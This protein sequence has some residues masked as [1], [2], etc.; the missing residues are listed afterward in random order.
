MLITII[1]LALLIGVGIIGYRTRQQSPLTYKKLLFV[2]LIAY[3]VVRMFAPVYDVGAMLMGLFA[4]TIGVLL[5]E[6]LPGKSKNK[7][8]SR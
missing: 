6:V 4:C 8:P 2:E 1:E 7:R 5:A 3:I